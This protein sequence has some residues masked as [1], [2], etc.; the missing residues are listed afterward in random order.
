VATAAAAPI[1][2]VVAAAAAHLPGVVAVAAPLPEMQP[3]VVLWCGGSLI[4]EYF[5]GSLEF[6]MLI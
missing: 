1:P 5:V 2:D 4:C 3:T 6:G